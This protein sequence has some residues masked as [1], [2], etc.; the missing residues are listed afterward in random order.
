MEETKAFSKDR[1]IADD[2]LKL[3]NKFNINIAI[4]TGTLGG[5]TTEWLSKNFE[6]VFTVEYNSNNYNNCLEKLKNISNIKLNLGD[7]VIFIKDIV[8]KHSNDM[9]LFYLDAHGTLPTPT[10]HELYQIVEMKIKPCIV[11]H[12]FY[13][14]GKNFNYD[15]YTDFDYKIENIKNILDLIYG[16]NGY[17]YFYNT[18]TDPIGYNVGCIFITP[19]K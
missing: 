10:P 7:S 9:C 19:K 12:D 4:E 13:V 15:T 17:V 11:I 18:Q 5:E 14:P 2:V 16:V 3:K 6:K 8:K 1:Y